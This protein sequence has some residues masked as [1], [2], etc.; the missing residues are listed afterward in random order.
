MGAAWASCIDIGRHY[1]GIVSGCMNT[2]GNLGGAAAGITT[3]W[4]LDYSAPHGWT[5]NFLVFG[6]V[7]VLAM[8][9]WL[10]FD[11]TEPLVPA[12]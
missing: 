4:I 2:V 7:Y 3:G 1:S 10:R 6:G 12:A 5:I 11:A 8:L 9:L